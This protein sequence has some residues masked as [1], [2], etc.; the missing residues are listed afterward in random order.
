MKLQVRSS[1]K[2]MAI[3]SCISIKVSSALFIYFFFYY[4]YYFILSSLWK[5]TERKRYMCTVKNIKSKRMKCSIKK[6]VFFTMQPRSK[7]RMS[8]TFHAF[9]SVYSTTSSWWYNTHLFFFFFFNAL[10]CIYTQEKEKCIYVFAR[11]HSHWISLYQTDFNVI[12]IVKSL[13]HFQ[14]KRIKWINNWISRIK[15]IEN[16][17]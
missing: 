3:N 14:I 17:K 7:Y 16:N 1:Q 4:F 2:T 10:S 15:W 5:S 6:K 11:E 13:A 12:S 8:H 9:Y